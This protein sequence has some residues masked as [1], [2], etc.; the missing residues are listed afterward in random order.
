MEIDCNKITPLL[1]EYIDNELDT[2]TQ[3]IVNFHLKECYNCQNELNQLTYSISQLKILKNIDIPNNNLDLSSSI[4]SK[5]E[6]D[7]PQKSYKK[8]LNLKY[9]AASIIVIGLS[10]FII[11]YNQQTKHESN[12][13]KADDHLLADYANDYYSIIQSNDTSFYSYDLDTFT[14]EN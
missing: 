13:N 6:K 14:D 11:F 3:S 8:T 7:I 4:I 1:S 9:I 10:L 5:I 2:E 12:I